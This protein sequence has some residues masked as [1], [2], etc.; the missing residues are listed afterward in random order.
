MSLKASTIAALRATAP[1][2]VNSM[3]LLSV[4]NQVSCSD[5]NEDREAFGARQNV[6]ARRLSLLRCPLSSLS[7]CPHYFQTIFESRMFSRPRAKATRPPPTKR[8]KLISTI[9]EIAFDPSAREDYL[10]GFHKRKLQRIKHAKE[11]AA[12]REREEQ[13]TARKIVSAAS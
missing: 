13:L 5:A 4:L 10:T 2:L 8:R 7:Q 11:E 3:A 12:K 6:F 1:R 9:E